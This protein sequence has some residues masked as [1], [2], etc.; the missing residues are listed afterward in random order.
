MPKVPRFDVGCW[1]HLEVFLILNCKY[2]WETKFVESIFICKKPFS[3]SYC[4]SIIIIILWNPLR[5]VRYNN[6]YLHKLINLRRIKKCYKG[7]RLLSDTHR[8]L[9]SITSKIRDPLKQFTSNYDINWIF[10]LIKVST[11]LKYF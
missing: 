9:L 8:Q 7:Q 3:K 5:I 6:W 10:N 11:R 2:L 4:I 1:S